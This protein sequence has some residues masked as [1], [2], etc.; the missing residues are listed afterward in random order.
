MLYGGAMLIYLPTLPWCLR[1]KLFKFSSW[2]KNNA[3]F[4]LGSNELVG[5]WGLLSTKYG[6]KN[7][8]QLQLKKVQSENVISQMSQTIINQ[9]ALAEAVNVMKYFLTKIQLIKSYTK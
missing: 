2:P 4:K 3:K 6:D 8:M 1:A 5:K 9:Y 7:N